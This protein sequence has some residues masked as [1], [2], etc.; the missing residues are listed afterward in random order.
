[1][2]NHLHSDSSNKKLTGQRFGASVRTVVGSGLAGFV[3][4]THS[5][6][7]EVPYQFQAGT[8]AKASEVNAN[9]NQLSSE[10]LVNSGAIS[11]NANDIANNNS[12]IGTNASGIQSNSS[13]L[14]SHASQISGNSG[15]IS[16]N[17][18]GI[19]S[20]SG[21]IANNA[22]AISQNSSNISS[23]T[24]NISTNATGVSDNA[25]GISQNSSSISSNT[26]SIS[27]NTGNISTNTSAISQN[28][29]QLSSQS[30]SIAT[31][32]SG[33]SGNSSSISTNSQSISD[34]AQSISTNTQSIAATVANTSD[35]ANLI[36]DLQTSVS[37]LQNKQD[38]GV[39]SDTV[40]H[41][42]T[43]NPQEPEIGTRT[44]YAGEDSN[45]YTEVVRFPIYEYGAEEP[46]AITFPVTVAFC[47]QNTAC[48]TDQTYI[49]AGSVQTHHA[50]A[51]TGVYPDTL[52]GFP[53]RIEVSDY[54]EH[55]MVSN[56]F[57]GNYYYVIVDVVRAQV[58]IKINETKLVFTVS[59]SEQVN[60]ANTTNT[61]RDLVDNVDWDQFGHNDALVTEVL[62]TLDNTSVERLVV[63]PETPM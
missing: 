24:S 10:T 47:P 61:D 41:S 56:F 26:S 59:S 22:S 3:L 27:T 45:T 48:S 14:S 18:S 2:R 19:S 46:Y 32:S 44:T 6:V 53:A 49:S 23:N 43:H 37:D 29:S 16:S 60:F 17:T 55:M 12:A 42:Y 13:T 34:N 58:T 20:N 51:D 40:L 4:M 15:N 36:G 50:V 62:T 9:F 52:S 57:T 7:A 21:N 35:N 33:I 25:S 63:L 30:S 8:P 1:M 38:S 11:A 5:A 39:A 28:S 54:R 31:N